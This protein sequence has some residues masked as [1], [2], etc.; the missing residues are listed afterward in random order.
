MTSSNDWSLKQLGL[1]GAIVLISLALFV[2]YS[3]LNKSF[4]IG[5]VYAKTDA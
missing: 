3:T 1:S 4:Q 2:S 5:I